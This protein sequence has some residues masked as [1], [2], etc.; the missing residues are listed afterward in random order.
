MLFYAPKVH[1]MLHNAHNGI[2][3]LKL[4]SVFTHLFISLRQTLKMINISANCT[5]ERHNDSIREGH[6]RPYN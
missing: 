5:S 2:K 1:K 4:F 6:N 3:Y